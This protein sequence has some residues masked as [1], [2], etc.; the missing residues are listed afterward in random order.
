MYGRPESLGNSNVL[1]HASLSVW[2]SLCLSAGPTC[3][4]PGFTPTAAPDG[5]RFPEETSALSV[6]IGWDRSL[7]V[8]RSAL[9]QGGTFC[10]LRV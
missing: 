2:T 4:D 7:R 5:R 1:R 9:S 8:A 6:S 10:I 3:A